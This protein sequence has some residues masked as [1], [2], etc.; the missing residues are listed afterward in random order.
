VER[1]LLIGGGGHASDVLQAIEAINASEPTFAVVGILDDNTVDERRFIGRGVVQVGTIDDIGSFDAAYV[2]CIGWP[3]TRRLVVERIGNS[4]R[5]AR[6]LIHPR[7][8]VGV[9]VALGP[10]SLVLGNAHISPMARLGAHALVSYNATIGHD[11]AFG[12]FAS[13]MP[14]A[15]VSGDVSAG[16]GVLIGTGAIVRE[17]VSIGSAAR[18]GA[19]ATAFEDVPA[20][21]T[22]LPPRSSG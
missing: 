20:G 9:G 16:N 8:D 6:P 22:L 21:V 14:G 12:D 2:A 4:G 7:A 1:L 17:G 11:A 3:W 15:N 13:V 10:G 19:G 5:A 18:I